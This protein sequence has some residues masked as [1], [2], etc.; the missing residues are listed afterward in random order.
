MADRGRRS[1]RERPMDYG[2][3]MPVVKSQ[4]DLYMTDDGQLM[5]K[6]RDDEDSMDSCL[7]N[8]DEDGGEDVSW[9]T[10]A[11]RA[12][13]TRVPVRAA[14]AAAPASAV[15]AVLAVTCDAVHVCRTWRQSASCRSNTRRSQRRRTS[16]FRRS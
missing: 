9:S 4:R 11:C 7:V 15:H 14:L 5:P 13:Q 1:F 12:R 3:P 8:F 16:P 6:K 2:K 10:A